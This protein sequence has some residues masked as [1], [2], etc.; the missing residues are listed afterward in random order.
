METSSTTVS[1]PLFERRRRG[2]PA[3]P[4]SRALSSDVA[5]LRQAIASAR[6][7][8]TEWLPGVLAAAMRVSDRV[9]D[10][11]ARVETLMDDLARAVSRLAAAVEGLDARVAEVAAQAAADG[12]TGVL[13][14]AA[15]ERRLRA[16]VDA[17]R[18]HGW[19][20]SVMFCDLDGFKQFNDR[21]G[22]QAGDDALRL[23]ASALAAY[24]D[25][26]GFVGRYG[27]EEFVLAMPGRTETEALQVARAITGALAGRVLRM[28]GS[29][30]PLGA[31]TLS[32]GV[33]GWR[34]QGEDA[35]GLLRRAD[36]AM[37]R[38]KR[39][40]GNRATLAADA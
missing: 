39:A 3:G 10:G 8:A 23:V 38:A 27:G 19:A 15:L 12:L 24:P 4:V 16:A 5:V 33:A 30:E 28:R 17:A 11:A 21:H 37:Y 18:A 22:H 14:R 35:A 13:N 7:V 6:D 32:A 26:R 36:V 25:P 1:P 31:V 9:A 34:G 29:G 20:L 2:P 40:G